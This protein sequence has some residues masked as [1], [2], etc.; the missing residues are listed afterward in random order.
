MPQTNEIFETYY[1]LYIFI[2][3]YEFQ[4]LSLLMNFL[5]YTEF[6][7]SCHLNAMT[8]VNVSNEK[9]CLNDRI[10]TQ[11][12]IRDVLFVCYL[13]NTFTYLR[14]MHHPSFW[15]LYG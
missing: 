8:Y 2:I 7:I 13:D 11:I 12:I 1:L 9:A 4:V 10:V 15:Y 6:F 3:C 14:E 5:N